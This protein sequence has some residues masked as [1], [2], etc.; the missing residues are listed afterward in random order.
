MTRIERIDVDPYLVLSAMIRARPRH[1]RSI[2]VSFAA[3][4]NC[5]KAK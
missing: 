3:D 4:T 5:G 2:D 1:R